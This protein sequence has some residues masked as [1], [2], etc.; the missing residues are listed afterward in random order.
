MGLHTPEDEHQI[1]RFDKLATVDL[2]GQRI[3]N[4]CL[5]YVFARLTSLLNLS[6]KLKHDKY[7]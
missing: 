4:V 3:R 2:K 1:K 5:N 6:Q 7:C